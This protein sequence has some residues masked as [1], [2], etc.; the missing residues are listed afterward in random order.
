MPKKAAVNKSSLRP[1]RTSKNWLSLDV[2][3]IGCCEQ[4]LTVNG[5][6]QLATERL[7]LRTYSSSTEIHDPGLISSSYYDTGF[8]SFEPLHYPSGNYG[9]WGQMLSTNCT[10]ITQESIK[11]GINV[12]NFNL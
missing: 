6:L 8:S 11:D 9:F 5:I 10:N 7:A 2:S 1:R 3:P 4:S 12:F